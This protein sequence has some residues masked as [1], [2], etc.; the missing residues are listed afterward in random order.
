MDQEGD[1]DNDEYYVQIQTGSGR[2]TV[3]PNRLGQAAATV[4]GFLTCQCND[5]L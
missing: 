3:K 1:N 2:R 4:L 5:F